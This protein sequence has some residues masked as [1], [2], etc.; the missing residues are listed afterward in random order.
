MLPKQ[1]HQLSKIVLVFVILN[2]LACGSNAKRILVKKVIPGGRVISTYIDA[3]EAAID[4]FCIDAE[5]VASCK[6]DASKKIGTSHVVTG[7]L[8]ITVGAVC[9]PTPL[10]PLGVILI[11]IGVY[12]LF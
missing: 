11:I 8:L 5:N 12:F 6:E 7:I 9:I 2:M 4:I 3:T 1:S 10:A